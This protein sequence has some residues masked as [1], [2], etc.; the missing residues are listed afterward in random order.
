MEQGSSQREVAPDPVWL[1]SENEA[2]E[3]DGIPRHSA[4]PPPA[5]WAD[6]PD[7]PT[8]WSSRGGSLPSSILRAALTATAHPDPALH[9][10][11]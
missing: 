3:M 5:I 9:V 11:S 4:P 6:I 10:S 8:G 1:E 2:N 7:L